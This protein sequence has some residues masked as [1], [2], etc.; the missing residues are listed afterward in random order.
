M[1][2]KS[3]IVIRD[4]RGQTSTSSFA[5]YPLTVL[6]LG[7][8][9]TQW[10]ALKTAIIGVSR[11]ELAKENVKLDETVLSGLNATSEEARRELKLRVNFVGNSGSPETYVTIACP[12]LPALTQVGE[13]EVDIT[14]GTA[15]PNLVTAM[16]TIMVYPGT[17]AETIT[18]T[19]AQ[20]VG[21]NI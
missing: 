20:I 18:V 10:G 17:D 8:F 19:S 3:A 9:F 1:P 14:A 5:H 11:G 6:N 21:R 15:M 2:R 13:D 4:H 16:E 7:D 12:N